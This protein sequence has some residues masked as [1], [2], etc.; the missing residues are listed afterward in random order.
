MEVLTHEQIAEYKEAFSFFDKDNDG[1]L[2]VLLWV[3]TDSNSYLSSFLS[4]FSYEDIM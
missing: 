4:T 3:F 2:F 1:M